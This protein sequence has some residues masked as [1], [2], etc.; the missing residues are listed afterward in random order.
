MQPDF[1]RIPFIGV[2]WRWVGG[3]VVHVEPVILPFGG[4]T[5]QDGPP[6]GYSYAQFV[7]TG[8]RVD[9]IIILPSKLLRL[10]VHWQKQPRKMPLTSIIM[11]TVKRPSQRAAL[12]VIL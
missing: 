7:L 2:G 3:C 5:T 10:G 8:S 12:F 1:S 6:Q 4:G 9:S 11:N